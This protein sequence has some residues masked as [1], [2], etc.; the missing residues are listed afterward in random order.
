VSRLL[1]LVTDHP[2]WTILGVAALTLVAVAGIVDPR[3]GEPRIH[4]DPS[5]NR[6]MPEHDPQRVFY[7]RVRQIFGSDETLVV[8][9]VADD[10]FTPEHLSSVIQLTERLEE[11]EGVHHVV[12]LASAL[13]IRASDGDLDIAPF[14]TEVPRDPA[15]IVRIREE[16]LSNPIYAGNLVSRDG[17]ATALVVY[18]LDMSEREYIDRGIGEEIEAVAEAESGDA[19]VWIT[20]PPHIKA[21]TS[22]VLLSDVRLVVPMAFGLAC[23]VAFLSFRTA[24]GVLVPAGTILIALV[25]TI[26]AMG[27]SGRSLNLVTTILPPLILCIG[28]AYTVHVIS[29]Y[30]V[31][32]RRAAGA[33]PGEDPRPVRDALAHV[34]GPVLLTGITTCAGFLSLVL[35]PLGA[36]REFAV[37]ATLGTL[38]T[39]ATSLTFAPAVLQLLP[40]PRR[41]GERSEGGTM[42]R[43]AV[44]LAHFAVRRRS[45]IFVSAGAVA[46]FAVAG[47]TRIRVSNDLVTNFY[48]DAPVRQHFEAINESLGG[49]NP[50]YVVLEADYRNAF[51]DP[52]NLERIR[53][54][55][56]WLQALPDVGSATSVVDYLMLINRGFHD[57]DPAYL[58]IPETQSLA[59][60]LLF[61]G[62]NDE[63]ENFVDSRR[64]TTAIL[65]R[66][67]IIDSGE[68]A[69]LV[70]RIEARL[71]ELP[72]HLEGTV[73]GNSVLVS[74][75]VDSLARGQA[76]SLSLAFVVIYAILALLFTSFRVGFV[77]L[78]PN[79]LPVVA[80]F[81][82]LGWT[83]VTLD[84]VT[85]LVACIVLG[86]AVDDTIHYMSRFSVEAK[87]LAD[88]RAGTVS[89]MRELFRPVT[90]TSVALC[91]GFLVVTASH[92]RNQ[93][94]FGALAAFTLGFA[95]LVDVTL[96]PALCSRVRIVTLW[97]IMTLDLGPDPHRSVPIFAG[98]SRGRA[99]IVALMMTLRTLGRGEKLFRLGETGE[100]M[101]VVIDGE[102]VASLPQEGGRRELSRLH[103]GDVVGEVALFHGRRT[104]DVD[105]ASDARLLRITLD[106][107]ERLRRRY[108]RIGA[109]VYRNLSRTLADL[110][111]RATD[112]LR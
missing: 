21:Q 82:T 6:L 63:L 49:S 76:T 9:L 72:P 30:Y 75:T 31:C 54:L 15:E 61:F 37:F 112:R 36:I 8:A 18:L 53:D 48:P 1:R 13:N 87:R 96:T 40:L 107:L 104:A 11:V 97:D 80:Y 67:R 68:L 92:L 17:R 111:A 108:P 14:L 59:A 71:A 78:L 84:A 102:L 28:F 100:D 77:A 12:S 110:V 24:R 94:H 93:V 29:E 91:A 26:G 19:S 27:W 45:L 88:E 47:I 57:D 10:V 20:G 60:Q 79:A 86:I 4:L 51:T 65:V 89:A 106:D 50:L 7:D 32:A 38:F 64:Q 58:A 103:R 101:Y 90:Y 56:E 99:R 42:D 55:Q 73:T 74:R 43:I 46:L 33:A 85:G 44:A 52:A 5:L 2:L 25:W 109:Q 35:S 62:A 41:L 16:A 34:A 83:G 66:S 70:H 81:G 3:S 105:A 95:W 23:L 98:L 39:L 22:R 69:A